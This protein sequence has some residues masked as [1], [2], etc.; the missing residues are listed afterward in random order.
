MGAKLLVVEDH[1]ENLEL[2]TYL[3]EA[4]G[5]TVLAAGAG[6]PGL[7]TARREHPELIICDIQ[8]PDIDG[9]EF[10]RRL[11]ADPALRDTPLV[12]VTALAMV[13]D[14]DRVLG[15]GF[16]GY[17]TKPIDAETFVRQVE[18][19]LPRRSHGEIR[20][21]HEDP[22]HVEVA[23]AQA[24][25]TILA[26]DNLPINL[27]LARS[28]FGPSGFRVFTAGSMS[29]GLALARENE[30]HLIISDVCMGGGSGLDFLRAVR[31]DPKLHSI[32]FV[33]LTSTM[34]ADEDRDGG[35]AMGAD[36]YLRRPI[37]PGVLLAEIR[38]CL[39]EKGIH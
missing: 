18:V 26:V 10:A 12:A 16:D 35:L 19:F 24:R 8:L 22:E 11:H 1:P 30:C 20:A 17:L 38:E 2:M 28:I 37:E 4:F 5:H 36:R 27:E 23:Q 34:M 6:E 33:L 3:L 29:E 21:T 25:I 13:G 15:A 32:P 9:L 14:R 39:R 7:E 31:A